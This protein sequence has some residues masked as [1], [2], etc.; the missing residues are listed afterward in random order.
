[1][2]HSSFLLFSDD[3]KIY[4]DVKSVENCKFLQADIFSVNKCGV[5]KAIWRFILTQLKVNLSRLKQTVSTLVTILLVFRFLR[6]DCIKD[7]GGDPY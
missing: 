3:L 1:M 5:V 7:F 6:N 4:R 2:N